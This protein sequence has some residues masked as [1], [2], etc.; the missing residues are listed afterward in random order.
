MKFGY[1]LMVGPAV[2]SFMKLVMPISTQASSN[3]A[4]SGYQTGSSI[5][6][7]VGSVISVLLGLAIVLNAMSEDDDA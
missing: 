5:G 2:Q 4:G 1:F 3:A 7:W 6:G